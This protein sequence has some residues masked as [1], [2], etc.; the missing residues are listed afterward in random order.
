MY[1]KPLPYGE[2]VHFEGKYKEDKLY[3]LYVQSFTCTFEVK[4]NHIPTIQIKK[5]IFKDNE[6]LT[7]SCGNEV[8]LTLTSIDLEL[9]FKH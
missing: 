2:G 6:Y 1:Y 8:T 7:S 9:F 3:N 4:E 5:S